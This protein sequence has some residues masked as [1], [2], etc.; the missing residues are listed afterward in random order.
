MAECVVPCTRAPVKRGRGNG[1]KFT[2]P[3]AHETEFKPKV[4]YGFVGAS[5]L[6]IGTGGKQRAVKQGP[7][8]GSSC[9]EHRL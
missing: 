5:E 6:P 2:L 8:L 7:S 9:V 1:A 4:H 3:C